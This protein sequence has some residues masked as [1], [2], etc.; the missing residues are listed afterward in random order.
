MVAGDPPH[1]FTTSPNN[2]PKREEIGI[3]SPRQQY[4]ERKKGETV[5]F[6][7]VAF[8]IFSKSCEVQG[9]R[10]TLKLA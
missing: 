4:S 5:T 7:R 8:L 10:G 1:R 6:G 2:P 3:R 9:E